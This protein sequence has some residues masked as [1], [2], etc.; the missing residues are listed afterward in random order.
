MRSSRL[1][2]SSFSLQTR[3]SLLILLLISPALAEKPAAR[4]LRLDQIPMRDPFILPVKEDG[5]Y[6]LYG[7]AHFRFANGPGFI[8]YTSKDLVNWEGPQPVFHRPPGFWGEHQYWAPEVHLYNGRYYMLAT[9]IGSGH[10]RGTAVLVADR[11]TGP[12]EPLSSNAVTPSSDSCLDGTLFIEDGKPWMVYSH[13]FTQIGIGAICAIRMKDDLSAA[14]GQ[15]IVLFRASDAPWAK[16]WHADGKSLVTDGPF[17]HKMKD[18]SLAMLWSSFGGSGTK[19]VYCLGVAHSKSGRLAGPWV[20]EPNTLYEDDGGHGMIFDTFD[21]TTIL[22]LHQPN[23]NGEHPRLFALD[24]KDG[25]LTITSETGVNQD[26]WEVNDMKR[27]V[28]ALVTPANKI[29]DPPADAIVLFDGK[30]L[31][32]WEADNGGDAPWIVNDGK[33]EIKPRTGTI[34]TKQSF[35]DCQLHIEWQT[36]NDVKG[37]GQLRGNSGVFLQGLYEIQVLDTHENRTYADGMAGSI[38]GQYPPLANA[39]RPAGQWQ[40]YDI[41][42]R[43]PRVNPDGTVKDPANIT[44]FFNGILVQDHMPA[45]G[46]TTHHALVTYPANVPTKG[47]LALQDHGDKVYYRNIWLREI[48]EDKPVAPVRSNSGKE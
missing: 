36:P 4:A 29:G 9:F 45:L 3:L 8:V 38:Y 33:I 6:Y 28:P 19:R 17:L 37:E 39:A 41:V 43:H 24:D 1:L 25:K 13:E 35:G 47:P 34:H 40:A 20:Q 18:G 15:P 12:F 31:S 42:F 32:K 10:E 48:P 30:D 14:D 5:R 44:V 27:P 26:G 16:H 2:L 7:T 11:P 23:S 21:G 46:P 22:A